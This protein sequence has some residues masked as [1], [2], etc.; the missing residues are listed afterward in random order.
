MKTVKYIYHWREA[1][2]RKTKQ[3][4]ERIFSSVDFQQ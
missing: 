3:F 2:S 1:V 4:N